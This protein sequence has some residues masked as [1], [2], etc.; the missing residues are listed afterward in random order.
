MSL[1]PVNIDVAQMGR[2]LISLGKQSPDTSEFLTLHGEKKT[3]ENK[4]QSPLAQH[5]LAIQ[6]QNQ[7]KKFEKVGFATT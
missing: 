7:P 5:S 2:G 4:K 3:L 6:Q 1:N